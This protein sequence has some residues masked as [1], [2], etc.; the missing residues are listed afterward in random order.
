MLMLC[1]LAQER[2][3][4]LGVVGALPNLAAIVHFE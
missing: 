4:V 2:W 1:R 3:Q